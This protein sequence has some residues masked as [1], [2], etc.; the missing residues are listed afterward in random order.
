MDPIVHS[1][2]VAPVLGRAGRSP[3]AFGTRLASA[4]LA[5]LLIGV[6]AAA[7]FAGHR[8]S[9]QID[10]AGNTS[11]AGDL[12]RQARFFAVSE[13]ADLDAYRLDRL[14]A[15]LTDYA[16]ST[17]DL[18]ATLAALQVHEGPASGGG[19]GAT[20]AGLIALQQRYYPLAQRLI[21]YVDAGQAA[22][23]DQLE[24]E[25]LEPLRDELTGQLG[26]LAQRHHVDAVATLNAAHRAGLQV[27]W[28]T[29]IALVLALLLVAGLWRIS[30][31]HRKM[32]H[33]QGLYDALTGLPNR[34][35]FADRAEHLLAAARRSGDEPVVM[36]VDLDRFRDVNETLGHRHGDD[37]LIQVG[38]RI[39]AV[40][41]PGDTVARLGGDEFGLLVTGGGPEAGINVASRVLASLQRPFNLDGVAVGIEAS[42]GI[43]VGVG[44]RL[45]RATTTVAEQAAQLLRDAEVALYQA[46]TDR[47]GLRLFVAST[48]GNTTTRL[49]LLG[50]LRQALE[51]DELVLHYQPKI[52]ADTGELLGVEALVRWEHPTRGLLAPGEFIALAESTTLIDP[53]T[54]VVLD[55]ALRFSRSWL[56]L[57]VR[58]PVAVNISARSLLDREFASN[59]AARLAERELPPDLLWIELTEGTIMSD[60]DRAI[61]ILR[62]LR[63]IGVRL[64]VD[65]FGTGY[66]SMAYLK[67]LPV[68]ELK[69]DRSFVKG[70]TID[71]SDAVLVQSAI[72]LGH[73]LGLSV[74]AEGVEDEPTLVALK[75]LR[76]DVVQGYHLGRPMTEANLKEWIAQRATQ[77]LTI[78]A[79]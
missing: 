13:D 68:D 3:T 24:I 50:E 79:R 6:P 27:R 77:Q 26:A 10:R 75:H 43:A 30:R 63:A 5:V 8:V 21:G 41:R 9:L 31:R 76:V 74:V 42:I 38:A 51:R 49:A 36:L 46:K 18:V 14:A 65:D 28:G 73:N 47:C 66:S 16:T 54:A 22:Q 62:E 72:D 11:A 1:A 4:G 59:I 52:A 70:M 2:D 56:D 60:A 57:G 69:I 15:S 58:L 37:L 23:A 25:Q 67:I 19:D 55:K 17:A 40:L 71:T 64:S 61:G 20:V 29:P 44:G 35:L 78:A 45:G 32:V 53:L 39:G 12:Y 33:H 7:I 48:N 34:S